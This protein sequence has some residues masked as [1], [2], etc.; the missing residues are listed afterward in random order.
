LRYASRS[1]CSVHAPSAST[2]SLRAS[3]SPSS[4]FRQIVEEVRALPSAT[5][6]ACCANLF[7]EIAA[8]EAANAANAAKAA[9]KEEEEEEDKEGDKGDKGDK[10]YK[11]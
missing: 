3:L 10:G 4:H 7:A 6:V 1:A 11:V 8:L 2:S 9:A 5:C